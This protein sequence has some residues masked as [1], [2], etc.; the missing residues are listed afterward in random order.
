MFR[1]FDK[2][3]MQVMHWICIPLVRLSFFV[4][5]FYFGLLKVLGVSPAEAV[6]MEL[7][8]HTMR[9]IPYHTFQ[10]LFGCYEMLIG[11]IFLIPG[12]ERIALYLL[13]PHMIATFGPLVLLPKVTWRGFMVPTL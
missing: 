11:L 8:G 2:R 7:W 1:S 4:V 6:V 3:F 5:Y 10:A 12:K 9:F 13:I